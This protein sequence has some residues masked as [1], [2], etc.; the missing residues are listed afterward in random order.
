[1]SR[2]PPQSTPPA[3]TG[4][5]TTQTRIE[6][7]GNT[8]EQHP[9][10]TWC[11]R[12]QANLIAVGI[13]LL[14]VTTAAGLGLALADAALAGADRQPLDRAAA[15]GAAD[16]LVAADAPTTRRANVLDEGAIGSLNVSRLEAMAPGVEGRDVHVRLDGQ[17]L[18]ERGTP[19]G[20][21]AIRRV[22][23]VAER[24]EA[25][26]TIDLS[27][28]DS[29]TLPRRTAQV[30][31]AIDPGANT[32][33]TTVR[34]DDRVVL[35]SPGGLDGTVTVPGSRYETTT[36]AFEIR[37]N[38]GGSVAVTYYPIQTSKAVLEVSVDA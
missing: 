28:A 22:V 3:E 9:D 36:L 14:A 24:T 18:F 37:G 32:T 16:R 10:R 2:A 17:Q 35:H 11:C 6:G 15:E 29:V 8:P 25:T 31:L 4:G 21:V 38:G 13:A 33:V 26:R 19:E 5:S 20:G 12:G 1:M 23:L 30:R 7:E 27:E 34:I